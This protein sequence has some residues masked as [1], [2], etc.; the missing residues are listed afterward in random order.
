M[1]LM[2]ITRCQDQPKMASLNELTHAAASTALAAILSP[3][4]ASA[5]SF[6]AF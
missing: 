1:E 5:A 6:P 2:K 3:P 4:S